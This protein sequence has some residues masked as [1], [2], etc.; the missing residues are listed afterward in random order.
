MLCL[1]AFPAFVLGAQQ[2]PL[3]DTT[4]SPFT[5]NFDKLVSQELDHWHTPGLAIAVIDGEDTFSKVW[6]SLPNK[7]GSSM[8]WSQTDMVM[9][10]I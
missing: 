3:T 8:G 7:S 4:I 9:I 6:T 2:V 10:K 1:A 5:A